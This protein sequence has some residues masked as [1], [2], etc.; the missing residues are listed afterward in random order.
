MITGKGAGFLAA[1]LALFILGHLTQ[2]GWLYLVDAVLWGI[3]LVS[4]AVPWLNVFPPRALR[5]IERLEENGGPPSPTEGDPVSITITL[6]NPTFWPRYVISLFYDCPLQGPSRQMQ[7]FFVTE[8]AGSGQVSMLS[9]VPAYQ[10]GSHQLGPL[11][12]EASAP[13]GLFRRRIRLTGPETLLVY[14]KLYPLARLALADSLSGTEQG[15]WKSRLGTDLSGSRYYLPGDPLRIIHWRNTARVG[16]PMVKEFDNSQGQTLHLL[17]DATQVWG[18]GK[19]TT[20]EYGIKILAS[21]AAYARRRQVPVQ[22]CG[23]GL[24][25][26]SATSPVAS[27]V[28]WR[29]LLRR[30]ALVSPGDGQGM[31]EGLRCVPPG[32][33]ALAVVSIANGQAIQAIGVLAKNLGGLVVVTLEGF[34]EPEPAPGVFTALQRTGCSLVRCRQGKLEDALAALQQMEV[35]AVYGPGPT[36]EPVRVQPI[37]PAWELK[38]ETAKSPDGDPSSPWYHGPGSNNSPAGRT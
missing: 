25:R 8:L 18:R 5:W 16:R 17:F 20:L 36:P 30:L 34:G 21:A 24:P 22:V 29:Q 12:M 10:R 1:A 27:D 7:R 14:P 31:V 13:F 15:G 9:N 33:M 3:I 26:E 38:A 4:A 11:M 2:V 32:S 23:D 28:S 6:R 37:G 19:E 35:R